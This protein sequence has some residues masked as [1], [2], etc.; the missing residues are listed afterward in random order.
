L[1]NLIENNQSEALEK[2]FVEAKSARDDWIKD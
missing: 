1:S 2:L